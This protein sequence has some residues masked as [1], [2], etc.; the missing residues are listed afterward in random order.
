MLDKFQMDKAEALYRSISE[1]IT[2]FNYNPD[3]EYM[4]DELEKIQKQCDHKFYKGQ[5]LYCYK[6]FK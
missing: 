3:M 1:G 4:I 5:C 6:E 2:F